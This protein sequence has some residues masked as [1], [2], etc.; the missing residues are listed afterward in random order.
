MKRSKAKPTAKQADAVK[1]ERAAKIAR[2]VARCGEATKQHFC[3]A[4]RR[5]TGCEFLEA[6][7]EFEAMV[8]AGEIKL[9]RLASVGVLVGVYRAKKYFKNNSQKVC[10]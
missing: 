9:A 5:A 4:I 6:E 2:A 1:A 3:T 7:I 8:A 10:E